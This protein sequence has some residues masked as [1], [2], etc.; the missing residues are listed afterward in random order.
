MSTPI[1]VGVYSGDKLIKKVSTSF[2]APLKKIKE[3]E[4]KN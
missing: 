1:E 4:N 2:L 3:H